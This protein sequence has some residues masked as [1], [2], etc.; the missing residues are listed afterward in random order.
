MSAIPLDDAFERVSSDGRAPRK[1]PTVA[2]IYL[3]AVA[4][5]AIGVSLPL[6]S[7][8]KPSS[9]Y[10]ITFVILGTS[11]ALA[12][13][14][15]VR[16]PGNKSYHTTGVFLI[17]AALLLPAELVALIAVVQHLPDW[18]RN[19]TAWYIQS[20][21][22]FNYTLATLGAWASAH[23]ILDADELIAN[24]DV[25]F[26]LAG[27]AASVCFVG[28]NSALI[29]PMLHLGR[30]QSMRPLLLPALLHG[31]RLRRPR[32]RRGDV[33]DVQPVADPVRDRPAAAHSPSPVRAAAP[34]GGARGSQDRALQRTSLLGRADGRARP[35]ATLRA[36][37]VAD[38]GR[39]RPAAR[40]QQHLRPP[41]RRCRSQ[42]HRRRLPRRATSLR[43]AGAV[44][45]RGVQH[46]AARDA[47][48]GG[49]RDRGAHP[50]CGRRASGSTSRPRASRSARPS[51]SASRPIRRTR[52]IR[53]RSSTRPTSRSTARSCRAATACSA[54]ARSRCT[55]R[56]S[57]SRSSW[58]SRRRTRAR[59]AAGRVPS[60]RRRSRRTA[61]RVTRPPARASLQ[62]SR[63]L[64]LVVGLVST[65]GVGAGIIGLLFGSST[66]I[67]GMLAIVALVG[68]GQALALELDDGAISVSAVGSLAGAAMFGSRVALAIA[69]TTAVVD[70]SARRP[71]STM[72]SSTSA[73]SRSRAWRRPASR[74]QASTAA[75]ASS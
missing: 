66:D 71:R 47:A 28:L 62:L 53:T 57:G 6:L 26:A 27:L 23:A 15:V 38:H 3:L 37:D 68:V 59:A 8:L 55:C 56:R 45:R 75:W 19:R 22:I 14:F 11:V 48:R 29:A 31:A 64:A 69:V 30:G 72:S 18:L 54:R 46:P 49:A 4:T 73:R 33:L 42:G 1:L 25:R 35:R 16:T 43:R 70:W 51:R 58:P 67:V 60:S 7:E 12:Q 21:N 20:F 32:R 10:W 9:G 44:R 50:A 74:P 2:L 17:P 5:V 40:D 34:G 39:P 65:V 61:I 63:R 24:N 36:P 41:R 52:R 13:L